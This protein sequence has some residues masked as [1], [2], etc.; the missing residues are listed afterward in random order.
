MGLTASKCTQ[1]ST[2]QRIP[3]LKI[4]TYTDSA[5]RCSG[6]SALNAFGGPHHGHFS[7]G[8]RSRTESAL[9]V[10]ALPDGNI[11]GAFIRPNHLRRKS[12]R[13]APEPSPLATAEP[14]L[15]LHAS[16]Y[17]A[18]HKYGVN[19][20]KVLALDK[21]KIQLTRHWLVILFIP[22]LMSLTM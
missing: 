1:R 10:H 9:T 8:Y 16:M 11:H 3:E 18:G 22:P 4:K 21:F 12:N 19:G 13:G 20:L 2:N 7:T 15:I 14:N 6:T 17:A 5:S